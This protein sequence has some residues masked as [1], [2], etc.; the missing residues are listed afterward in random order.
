MRKKS[1]RK[2]PPEIRGQIKR[3]GSKPFI[4]YGV[5]KIKY[6]DELPNIPGLVIAS[7]SISPAETLPAPKGLWTRRNINGWEITRKDW[8]KITKTFSHESPNFG[9]W[10]KGSH[11]VSV[12]REVYQRE[13]FP[14]HEY[15]IRYYEIARD[16]MY[17]TIGLE[18]T[19]VFELMPADAREFLFALNVF[20]ESVGFSAVRP[21]DSPMTDYPGSLKIDWEILPVGDREATLAEVKRKL[22][23]NKNEERVIEDRL[24]LLL[25]MKP[26]NLLTGT[27]G[28]AR[29]VGAQYADDLVAFENVRYGNALYI[30]YE[31]WARLS[32]MSRVDLMASQE[33]FERV[34]HTPTWKIQAKAIIRNKLRRHR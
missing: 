6:G 12:E 34:V 28:F 25:S 23:P 3:C 27:S 21:S 1:F 14:A 19:R 5:V 32:K 29:Y 4:I 17:V 16:N 7:D 10:S 33:N 2:L 30:M 24:W 20:Q 8:P 26:K 9:D 13:F 22:A 15:T 31:D 18:L 11:T